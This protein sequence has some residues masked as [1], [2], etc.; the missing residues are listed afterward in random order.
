MGDTAPLESAA[1]NLGIPL[2][3][4]R[5]GQPAL[6]GIYERNM[7]LV[8]PDQHV[9]WRGDQLPADCDALLQLVAGLETIAEHA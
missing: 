6:I 8:R 5:L 7:I 9:A 4:L 2:E 1:A 3:V